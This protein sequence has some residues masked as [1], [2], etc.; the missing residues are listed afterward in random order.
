[1]GEPIPDNH[2]YRGMHLP[3]G[4]S[5]DR[6]KA[7][8]N[9]LT[10]SD[11]NLYAHV[12]D[13]EN[14]SQPKENKR[15]KNV[16]KWGVLVISP[17][18]VAGAIALSPLI[19][20][21]YLIKS[22]SVGIYLLLKES[23][24]KVR[25]EKIKK[26]KDFTSEFQK[27]E[28]EVEKDILLNFTREFQ[29][30][31]AEVEKDILLN[32]KRKDEI[33]FVANSDIENPIEEA[34][35]LYMDSRAVEHLKEVVKHQLADKHKSI[36]DKKMEAFEKER[37]NKG[38]FAPDLSETFFYM[39][40]IGLSRFLEIPNIEKS[41]YALILEGPPGYFWNEEMVQVLTEFQR[42]ELVEK[43]NKD[44][45]LSAST[46]KALLKRDIDE[47]EIKYREA[48]AIEHLIELAKEK[49]RSNPNNPE[50]LNALNT[51][52]F[53]NEIELPD[54]LFIKAKIQEIFSKHSKPGEE[55]FEILDGD[56]DRLKLE[57]NK[58][59]Y[60]WYE[61][62]ESRERLLNFNH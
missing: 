19:V 44:L 47:I 45:I 14:D 6:I 62:S 5:A 35:K 1:M 3:N 48:R 52:N 39:K 61:F 57:H 22:I 42:I 30:L 55:K 60:N 4:I 23:L 10:A 49:A 53:L 46:K 29:K 32:R 31:E 21:L 50:L 7:D 54:L 51:H 28:A 37:E 2:V 58:D 13:V 36:L 18:L 11:E 59:G 17:L 8:P 34:K 12:K 56:V 41:I 43:I 9:F 16:I 27:L 15:V 26:I 40:H 38:G 24:T 33:L 20:P 25:G